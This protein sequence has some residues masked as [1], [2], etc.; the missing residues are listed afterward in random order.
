MKKMF[1]YLLV[2][3]ILM[4]AMCFSELKAQEWT[5]NPWFRTDKPAGGASAFITVTNSSRIKDLTIMPLNSGVYKSL[6]KERIWAVPV[7]SASG[8]KKPVASKPTEALHLAFM[9]TYND[10]GQ[11]ISKIVSGQLLGAEQL[12]DKNAGDVG[13]SLKFELT[14]KALGL[15]PLPRVTLKTKIN[16][17]MF[18][19]LGDA[20]FLVEGGE[21]VNI[22]GTLKSVN[23]KVVEAP[24]PGNY[25]FDF[26]IKIPN[27]G[28]VQV[29]N[30]DGTRKKLRASVDSSGVILTVV[31]QDLSGILGSKDNT[32][33]GSGRKKTIFLRTFVS[34]GLEF[35][36]GATMDEVGSRVFSDKNE[37]ALIASERYT[38]FSL[39]AGNVSFMYRPAGT[40]NTNRFFIAELPVSRRQKGKFTI[41]QGVITSDTN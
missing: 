36:W 13:H 1:R 34:P 17:P 29:W 22:E 10:G 38:A 21:A 8:Y 26:E 9:V 2:P 5:Q 33:F 19:S 7:A 28:W 25:D 30:Q 37:R 24:E 6:L 4:V 14:D 32:V 31:P 15:R 39:P 23:A 16:Y 41:R 40:T 27:Y 3:T 35:F 20:K 12:L 18:I 11:Q